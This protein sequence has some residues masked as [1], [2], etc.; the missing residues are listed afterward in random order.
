[1]LE[2]ELDIAQQ[3]LDEGDHVIFLCCDGRVE[4]CSANNNSWKKPKKRYCM[5]CQ[6][7][8]RNGLS[9]LDA[10]SGKLTI[11]NKNYIGESELES[12]ALQCEYLINNLD[13]IIKDQEFN[14]DLRNHYVCALSGL[15]SDLVIS[16]IDVTLYKKEFGKE[17]RSAIDCDFSAMYSLQKY[18]PDLVYIYN[19]RIPAYNP[20]MKICKEKGYKFYVYEYPIYLYEDPLLTEGYYPHDL[21]RLSK[22]LKEISSASVIPI[23]QQIQLG[24]SWL[25]K[26][27]EGASIDLSTSYIKNQ[28]NLQ[29][30]SNWSTDE[31]NLVFFT[32]TEHE[33]KMVE[34]V[35]GK[36]F[37]TTQIDCIQQIV[38]KLDLD[39]MRVTIRMHPNSMKD[40]GFVDSF[41]NFGRVNRVEIIAPESP[42]DSYSLIKH[43]NLVITFGSTIGVESA[44]L[45]I[46]T[47]SLGSAIYDDFEICQKYSRLE[48][49]LIGIQEIFDNVHIAK[50]FRGHSKDQACMYAYAYMHAGKKA[51]YLQ[52]DTY[53]G[54]CMTRGNCKTEIKASVAV[55]LFNRFIDLR[56][57]LMHGI[58]LFLSNKKLRIQFLK[59]PMKNIINL[60]SY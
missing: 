17:L 48:D 18:D 8:V 11:Q 10:G 46:P 52:R 5:E 28:N 7:R 20:V 29:L 14:I 39:R 6:S 58:S 22:H 15:I 21:V 1:M 38:S 4:F 25:R 9:W 19:G 31:F 41:R 47:F 51:K 24:E 44:Y 36:N 42:I 37:F 45:G 33:F 54:G 43:A 12:Y 53:F 57:R 59:N 23:N 30:P 56:V 49:V 50:N 26:R 40:Q 13:K 27:V 3:H 60:I 2:Y 34:E 35:L 32:S 55:R 16:N